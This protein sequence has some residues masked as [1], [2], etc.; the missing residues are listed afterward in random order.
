MELS[1]GEQIYDGAEFTY[2][3]VDGSEDEED[4]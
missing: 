1:G 4:N 2:T 3:I